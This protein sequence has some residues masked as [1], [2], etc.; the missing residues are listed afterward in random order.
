[1]M[2]LVTLTFLTERMSKTVSSGAARL[3]GMRRA[4]ADANA[5]NAEALKAMGFAGRAAGRFEEVNH[6][7]LALHTSASDVIATLTGISKVLRFMLQA[8]ILGLGAFLTV[9]GEVTAGAI[10]AASIATSRA[11]APVEQAIAQWRGFIA[12]RQSYIRTA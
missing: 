11:L 9:G 2:L 5:R 12:A 8:G 10:I 4:V 1:M 7:F 3:D 6:Q